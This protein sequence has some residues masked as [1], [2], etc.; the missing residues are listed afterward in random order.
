MI[1]PTLRNPGDG[2]SVVRALE[3]III[4]RVHQ[5]TGRPHLLLVPL[6][7]AGRRAYMATGAIPQE[8]PY[9]SQK[10]DRAFLIGAHRLLPILTQNV[11]VRTT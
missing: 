1:R 11:L 9:R 7:S 8:Q 6:N 2:I 5:Y 3:V 10:V 4:R